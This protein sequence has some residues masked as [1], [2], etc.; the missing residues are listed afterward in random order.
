M[1]KIYLFTA[2]LFLA[3]AASAQLPK[4]YN[5]T[6]TENTFALLQPTAT[7]DLHY[8]IDTFIFPGLIPVNTYRRRLAATSG[9]FLANVLGSGLYLSPRRDVLER[10]KN[11]CKE[12]G[13]SNLSLWAQYTDYEQTIKADKNSINDYKRTAYGGLAGADWYDL[14]RDAVFGAYIKY[15][16]GTIK[17]PGILIGLM[18]GEN[19]ADTTTVSLGGYGGYNKDHWDF[20]GAFSAGFSQY[21]TKRYIPIDGG[22]TAKANFDAVSASLDVEGGVKMLLGPFALR[23]FVGA[24]GNALYHGSFN[25][26]GANS[27][28]LDVYDDFMGVA[29]LKGGAGLVFD[30]WIFNLYGGAEWKYLLTG[31]RQE[32]RA[33]FAGTDSYFTSRSADT[34]RVLQ[35]LGAGAELRLG[36][37]IRLF[38]NINTLKSDQYKDLNWNAGLRFAFCSTLSPAPSLKSE[39]ESKPAKPAKT[40]QPKY[41]MDPVVA[42]TLPFDLSAPAATGQVF[43]LSSLYFNPGI[44]DLGPNARAFLTKNAKLI[45]EKN[46]SKIYITGHTDNEEENSL[47]LSTARARHAAEFLISQ[48]IPAYK[49]DF[50]GRGSFEP[51]QSNASDHGR[52]MNRRVDFRII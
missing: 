28:N 16:Q 18:T 7:G 37:Q 29:S 5:M 8:I 44:S 19:S 39:K 3:S 40:K 35:G 31:N 32:V 36:S 2:V 20:T 1:K 30:M 38:G 22:R 49:I 12:D 13:C 4:S 34:G 51:A 25:E 15:M 27:L 10:I 52:T 6:Q 33:A 9:Y 21:R 23:P 14:D 47:S 45:R 42:E 26:S 24:E 43:K 48:G 50:S 46:Y 41:I 17:Q 11:H